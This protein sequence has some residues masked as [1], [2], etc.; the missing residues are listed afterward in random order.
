MDFGA[1]EVECCSRGLAFPFH[2]ELILGAEEDKH[3]A[4]ESVVPHVV[5]VGIAAED[6]SMFLERVDRSGVDEVEGAAGIEP[7]IVDTGEPSEEGHIQEPDFAEGLHN[8]DDFALEGF[9]RE[10]AALYNI[11]ADLEWI[12][13][14]PWVGR[15]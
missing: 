10:V 4:H 3:A 7:A 6:M 5:V 2:K 15:K 1:R 8:L 12:E 9:D 11:V 14:V 13:V